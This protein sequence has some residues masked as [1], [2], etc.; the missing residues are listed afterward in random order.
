[1]QTRHLS[2][3]VAA[4][5]LRSMSRAARSLDVSPQT[6]CA[7]IQAVE[8]ELGFQLLN[9]TRTGVSLTPRGEIVYADASA[10]VDAEARWANL[11]EKT[12][13]KSVDV[14]C[15][16]AL[17]RWIGA[18][19]ILKL[20]EAYPELDVALH[21]AFAEEALRAILKRRIVGMITCVTEG[22]GQI[23]RGQLVQQN[24]EAMDM[25]SDPCLVV[26]NRRHPLASQDDI[27]LKD[28]RQVRLACN[29]DG[30][31]IFIF[32]NIF[33]FFM[34][35]RP[36]NIPQQDNLLRMISIQEDLGAVLPA[37]ALRAQ[38]DWS[39]GVKG[40]R[41]R[42]FPMEGRIWCMGPKQASDEQRA[43]FKALADVFRECSKPVADAP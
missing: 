17:M 3:F 9:R 35:K 33:P 22:V 11:R 37:S 25:G 29:P 28:L 24:M 1:M 4:A 5:Q 6:L 7:G 40:V 13:R 18:A 36:L 39:G 2:Y 23:Y 43:V 31:R 38:G 15:C 30:H 32:R 14:M 19:L 34:E 10:L 8:K 41:V 16:T 27:E 26:L 21:V 42:D 12:P 20:H